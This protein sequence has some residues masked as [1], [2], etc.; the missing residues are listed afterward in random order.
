[1]NYRLSEILDVEQVSE[2]LKSYTDATG[3]VSALLDLDGNILSQSGWQPICT[4]FHRV[5]P[6]TAANC[7]TSDTTLANKLVE[8]GEFNVY[9]CLNGLVDV[10][11]P[12]KVN[13]HHIGNLFTGQFLMEKPNISYFEKQAKKYNFDKHKYLESLQDIPILKIEEIRSKLNF[14]LQMTRVIAE[15][16]LAKIKQ[17]EAID[18]LKSSELKFKRLSENSPVIIYQFKKNLDG[19][20]SFP[21]ISESVENVLNI[22]ASDVIS[23]VNILMNL[24]HPDDR[25]DN[26][27]AIE[28]SAN[29]LLKYTDELRFILPSGIT[30]W[31]EASSAPE[32][33]EDGSILWDGFFQDI[34]DRK[35]AEEATKESEEK[36]KSSFYTSPVAQAILTQDGKIIESNNAFSN[37]IGFS[38]EKIIGSSVVDLGLLSLAEREKL[39][40][41]AKKSGGTIRN[42]EVIFTAQD[43]S[44]RNVL[45]STEQFLLN[46]VPHRLSIGIDITDRKQAEKNLIES[47]K[48]YRSLFENMNA[49]FE[50]FEVVLNE[51]G[52][53]VDLIILAANEGFEKTTGLKL[54]DSIGKRLTQVLP[55][56]END[57]ADWIGTFSKVA[58][59]GESVQFEQGSE[60]LG[61]FYSVSAFQAGQKQC[62]VTFVDITDRKNHEKALKDEKDRIRTILDLV[63]DP[64]FV[65]DNQHRIT[66]ANQAFYGMFATDEKSTLGKTL[67]ES[68]PEKE[69]K[70]FLFVDRNVLDTGI[71]DL[72]EEELTIKNKTKTIVTKKIRFTDDSGNNFLVGSIHDITDRKLAE[73][74]LVQSEE[75]FKTSFHT[76]PTAQ[77]I[78]SQDGKFVESN[79]A[80]TRLIG[81]SKEEIIGNSAIDLG[82]LSIDEQTK[83]RAY[84]EASGG[85]IR[86]AEVIFTVKDGSLHYILYSVEQIVLNGIPHRLSMGIDITERKKLEIERQKFFMLAESSS[87]FIGMCDLELNPLYVNPAGRMMVG[88]PDMESA[89]RVKVQDYYF[90]EDQQF[91]AHDFFPRVLSEGHGDV[92]IRL[93]HFQTGEAIWV[94]HYLF[95]IQDDTGKPIGWATVSRDIT[96]RKQA[97]EHNRE[98]AERAKL[99]RNLIAKLSFEDVIANKSID[100]ALEIL[101]TQLANVLKVE[102]TSVW[103][104][105]EDEKLLKRR[106]LFDTAFGI[107]AQ[108][109]TLK[110]A[111]F[112]SYFKALYKDSQIDADDAQNDPRTKGLNENYFIPLRISSML[113]SAIQQDGR[114]IGVL[115]A[116]HRGPVRQWHAD[117]ESFVSALT[118]L[119]AQLFA[120]AKRKKAEE[121]LIRASRIMSNSQ[122]IA[123]LGSFEYV[124]A[125]QTTI[126]SEEEY[127][128]YGLDPKG[129]SP[130]Y[131]EMLEK[132]I[133]PDD[134][135]LLN[136][137]F[138]SAM[139]SLGTYELEHRIVRPD[140]SVRWVH[141]KAHPYFDE[142]GNLLRYVGATL[143]ITERKL[144][145]EELEIMNAELERKVEQRTAQLKAANKELETFTYSVSH[146]L[147]APLRGIDGYSRLLLNEYGN[148]LNEEATHFINTIRSSTVQMHQLIDDLLSYSRLE[149]SQIRYEKIALN[150][151]VEKLLNGY[152]EEFQETGAVINTKIPD[153]QVIADSTGLSIA[154][155]NYVEN[156]LKFTT[157]KANPII[158]IGIE[159][160]PVS[161]VIY[162]KDNGC[163]F[164]MK[165][166]D[167]I[168]EIFQRL[169]RAEDFQGTGIGLAMVAKALQRMGGKAWA[170]SAPEKGSTFY[171][172]IPKTK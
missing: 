171:I 110:T 75:K 24:I 157:E 35:R 118:N 11:V 44:F 94:Y 37:L 154:L 116:E 30:K 158:E 7:R 111:D 170:E 140:G 65:K 106:M 1:M 136:D 14:L 132:Y 117:E 103:L 141:D 151:F 38:K 12:L 34:T 18:I 40:S 53:P 133:H 142:K 32:K 81:Y 149:R 131:N 67:A 147:K 23:D 39:A 15:L 139:Q 87:E 121:E 6:D 2:L 148:K 101:T 50:L 83:L 84:A 161:R 98:S 162:V 76:N 29:K 127:R 167:R 46:G 129:P 82:L 165:Y 19:S 137:T 77:A 104:L 21:Y 108:V 159:E 64:I 72:R 97:E 4:E 90:P 96:E 144:L 10:A 41:H 119:L 58:L 93:R 143:D 27:N 28:E 3:L 68:V 56:I 100:E 89:C 107:D 55:G 155:R 153:I 25:D 51:Q 124:A 156:A 113:D 61:Y 54:R 73:K 60:L 48:Q 36:F 163:G 166:H 8:G 125:T 74:A 16:G 63:G 152:S 164:D 105:S 91:I 114:V 168:F 135:K 57:E 120:N 80:F 43:G 70:Q 160:K 122:E 79:E 22:R 134:A 115:S 123:H 5:N 112:P 169:H 47:E 17:I 59:S 88:L 62:A 138:I 69:K 42:A 31:I 85:T 26:N 92:E 150:P 49:G 109:E 33:Q 52:I 99:Q 9:K 78:L 71:Q 13:E 128:I 102:R 145:Q 130:E 95:R 86:N 20:Y 146:D 45:Y 66:M 126:W 172:E